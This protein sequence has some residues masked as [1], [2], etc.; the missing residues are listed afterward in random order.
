MPSNGRGS[1]PRRNL[2]R[3]LDRFSITDMVFVSV[4]PKIALTPFFTKPTKN[5][6]RERDECHPPQQRPRS[7]RRKIMFGDG[8]GQPKAMD[9]EDFGSG[10]CG[11]HPGGRPAD[12]GNCQLLAKCDSFDGKLGGITHPTAATTVAASRQPPSTGSSLQ[13]MVRTRKMRSAA[14]CFKTGALAVDM[15]ANEEM[16][17][18]VLASKR[19]KGFSQTHALPV[20]PPPVRSCHNMIKA[21]KMVSDLHEGTGAS[22]LVW[23]LFRALMDGVGTD[24]VHTL[25]SMRRLLPFWRCYSPPRWT[26]STRMAATS[27]DHGS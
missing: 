21:V 1:L 5:G 12:P 24:S 25:R 13:E 10:D 3:D 11:A 22:G 16:N 23:G 18:R 27:M 26:H 7:E 20:L 15:S 8:G 4:A 9:V 2:H 14:L 19:G 6:Q 17:M